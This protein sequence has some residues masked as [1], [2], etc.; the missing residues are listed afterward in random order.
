ME[1]NRR[2]KENLVARNWAGLRR[3]RASDI[4]YSVGR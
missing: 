4:G 1:E 2:A 3:K